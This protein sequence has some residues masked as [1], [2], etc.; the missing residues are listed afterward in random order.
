VEQ[1]SANRQLSSNHTL[2]ATAT[3]SFAARFVQLT[4]A[5]GKRIKISAKQ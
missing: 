3:V 4:G 1:P 5:K 2:V